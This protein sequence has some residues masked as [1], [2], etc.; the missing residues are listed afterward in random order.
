MRVERSLALAA[1]ALVLSAS[2]GAAAYCRTTT[3]DP[4]CTN[5]E[6]EC[7]QGGLPLFWPDLCVTFGVHEAGSQLRGISYA[8]AEEAT[9]NA[10]QTWISADCGKGQHPTIG[11]VSLGEIVCDQ[12]EYNHDFPGD[13][14]DPPKAAGPNANLVV[15]RDDDWEY[16]DPMTIALTTITFALSTGEI[17]D[18]DIEVNSQDM[19]ITTGEVVVKNDLQAVMTH[20]IGHFFGLAHS[21]VPGASMNPKYDRGDLDFRSISEDDRAG[22]CAIYGPLVG[23]D[24]AEG[25]PEAAIDCTGEGP[26]FGFSRYCG[27][28]S[29]ADGCSVAPP[30]ATTLETALA[31]AP[32]PRLRPE[33]SRAAHER[34]EQ[35][36]ER[37]TKAQR[38]DLGKLLG[39][40]LPALVLGCGV[41]LRRRRRR[42]D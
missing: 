34:A 9:R 5:G 28:D 22:M 36:A 13:E 10:F 19:E 7:P 20:E 17:L 12:I 8:K 1:A 38:A 6:M 31:E 29:L 4:E 25:D 37:R 14:D 21:W 15:F 11:V 41:A 30:R 32:K 40:G 3:C 33:A 16:M 35:E 39:L 26:R 2:G 27:D 42:G 24:N 23:S 18:A